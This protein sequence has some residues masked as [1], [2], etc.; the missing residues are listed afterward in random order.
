MDFFAIESARGKIFKSGTPAC[1]D[2]IPGHPHMHV[3]ALGQNRA[4]YWRVPARTVTVD[5]AIAIGRELTTVSRNLL[6]Q[7]LQALVNLAPL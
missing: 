2:L 1:F 5:G 4:L 6:L 3:H 7:L